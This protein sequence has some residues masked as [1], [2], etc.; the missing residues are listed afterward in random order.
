MGNGHKVV[1]TT[2]HKMIKNPIYKEIVD[3]DI[4]DKAQQVI[5]ENTKRGKFTKKRYASNLIK[6]PICGRN[7]TLRNERSWVCCGHTDMYKGTDKF[8]DNSLTI[9][10]NHMDFILLSYAYYRVFNTLNG[11]AVVDDVEKECNLFILQIAKRMKER[12]KVEARKERMAISFENG[13]YA[14]ETYLKRLAA[15]NKEIEALN[16]QMRDLQ[17]Q[18]DMIRSNATP[19]IQATRIAD[20]VDVLGWGDIYMNIHKFIKVGY[21]YPIENGRL[22]KLQNL[23]DED[24]NIAFVGKGAGVKMLYNKSP[25]KDGVYPITEWTDIT[26][27]YRDKDVEVFGKV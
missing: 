10:T 18:I 23:E 21:V 11:Q 5:A 27:Y 25:H 6:C 16:F 8:C 24:I 14:K 26:K 17:A 13:A 9:H 3:E 22:L 2:I 15:A 7:Y 20:L 12:K 19:Q 1:K 4:W